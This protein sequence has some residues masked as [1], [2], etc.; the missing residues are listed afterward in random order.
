MPV[1]GFVG[2]RVAEIQSLT[3][4]ADWRYVDTN[5][6]PA[7][8][9]TRGLHLA[10]LTQPHRWS[11]GPNFLYQQ[12]DEW[13]LTPVPSEE[14]DT[15]ELKKSAFIGVTTVSANAQLPDS[16]QFQTWQ[17]LV[18]PNTDQ[19]YNTTDVIAAEKSILAQSQLESFPEEIKA[20]KANKPVPADSRLS[21]L[22]PEFDEVTGLVRVGGR[23][24][25]AVDLEPEAI[26]TIVL[27]PSHSATRLLIQK[28][29]Q[30]LLH[31]GPE[32]VLA[33]RCAIIG[34]FG[35]KRLSRSSNTTAETA[36]SG[37]PSLVFPK[38]LTCHPADYAFTDRKSVV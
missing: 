31:P 7:D 10:A 23:L 6:N 5:Q 37:V 26:H 33:E 35:E 18:H 4:V 13:P 32:R 19:P 3:N 36:N 1:Q 15:C 14:P 27:D 25:R 2:T 21:S 38:W 30:Q 28:F 20:L 11:C 34:Y 16:S 12:P 24:R 17:D 22:A 8:D 9:L 29:D